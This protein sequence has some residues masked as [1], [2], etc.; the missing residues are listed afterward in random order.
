MNCFGIDVESETPV[1]IVFNATIS[2][3]SPVRDLPEEDC[4]HG[5]PGGLL[6]RRPKRRPGEL[7][8]MDGR[9]DGREGA[10]RKLGRLEG[11]DGWRPNVLGA[12]AA[13]GQPAS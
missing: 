13:G 5:K 8:G 10:G 9:G 6:Y 1:E 11:S 7:R 3:V 2:V 4:R 12:V